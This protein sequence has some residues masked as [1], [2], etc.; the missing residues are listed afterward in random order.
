MKNLAFVVVAVFAFFTS[1]QRVEGA[2]FTNF[3]IGSY[4]KVMDYCLANTYELDIY[5]FQITWT[6]TVAVAGSFVKDGFHFKTKSELDTYFHQKL[7]ESAQGAVTNTNSAIDKDAVF[8]IYSVGV[9]MDEES[10]DYYL[11][12]Y[13]GVTGVEFSLVK[14][15]GNYFVPNLSWVNLDFPSDIAYKVPGLNWARFEI[16]LSNGSVVSVVDSQIEPNTDVVDTTIR[17]IFIDRDVAISG[18][19]GNYRVKIRT[20]SGSGNDFKVF[21]SMGDQISERRPLISDCKIVKVGTPPM[22]SLSFKV[23]NGEIGRV[24]QI[25]SSP[26]PNGPWIDISGARYSIRPYGAPEPSF[27]LQKTNIFFR[28][29]SV[30]SIPY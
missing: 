28:V 7:Q 5:V 12:N 15:N 17:Q 29:K 9:G 8:K 24:F 14:S 13:F 23:I 2:G 20:V 26:T 1:F 10:G 6:G 18:T 11:Y 30:S 21:D 25:M 19:N 27:L 22:K 16:A 3:Q 4:S